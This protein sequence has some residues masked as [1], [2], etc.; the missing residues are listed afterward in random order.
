MKHKIK[1]A[2]GLMILPVFALLY[3]ADKFVLYFMPWKS[4]DT[5]QKWIYD[6]KKA[7]ESLVRVIVSLALIGLYY[8][9]AN[10]F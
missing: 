10:M 9:I 1:V 4:S 8:L 7:T 5:I 6:P 3:F 2:L